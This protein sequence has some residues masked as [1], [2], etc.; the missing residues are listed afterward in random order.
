M[1]TLLEARQVSKVFGGGLFRKRA[2][3]ALDHFSFSVDSSP[4]TITAIVGESG[5]GKTTLARL[6]LGL[7]SP[8]TGEVLYDGTNIRQLAREG[9]KQFLRDVQ[10]IFQDPYEV[11]NP[12]YRVEHVLEAPISWFKLASSAQARRALIEDSL[13]AVGLRPEETLGRYPHQL[14][15]GQRQRIMVARAVLIRPRLI[16]AD[17]PVSMVD[18]SLRAT[19]LDS[20][21]ELNREYGMSIVYITHDLTTAYQISDNIIVL[22]RGAVAEAGDVDLVVG[23]PR[24]P[25]TQLLINSVPAPDPEHHWGAIT[26]APESEVESNNGTIQID[27]PLVPA[28]HTPDHFIRGCSF[29]DRCPHVMAMCRDNVPP[30]YRL[31]PTRAAAC[32]LYHEQASALAPTHL[33]EV[34]RTAPQSV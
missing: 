8:S 31:D 34:M 19:I 25:Y 30:L 18:A 12:F 4:P 3:V 33:N 32:F 5:S 27:T 16:I 13:R 29:A 15:G 2:T 28:A 7:V 22:Y 17:E 11:Y 6:L 14:S 26:V 9:R 20:L 21:R 24:H 1:S 10:M 23:Q